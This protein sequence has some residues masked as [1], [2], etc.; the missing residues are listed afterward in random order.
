MR[1]RLRLNY[2]KNINRNVPVA[3]VNFCTHLRSEITNK[4][5]FNEK[6]LDNRD[7]FGVLI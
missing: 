4:Y 3:K 7:T 5:N 1:E 2:Y 6:L